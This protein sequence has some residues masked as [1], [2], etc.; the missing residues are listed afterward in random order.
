MCERSLDAS[1]IGIFLL[2]NS[3]Y[4]SNV[5]T[6]MTPSIIYGLA[7]FKHTPAPCSVKLCLS[8]DNLQSVTSSLA[9]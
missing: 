2:V 8:I 9:H 3:I 1:A 4:L 7:F 5:T 6:H